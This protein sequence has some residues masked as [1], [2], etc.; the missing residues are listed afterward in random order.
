METRPT[1]KNAPTPLNP[2]TEKGRL[3][4]PRPDIEVRNLL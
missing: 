4:V 2:A 3:F 1:T